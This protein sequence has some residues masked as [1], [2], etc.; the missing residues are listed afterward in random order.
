MLDLVYFT[1]FLLFL[2]SIVIL[3]CCY[4][5]FRSP[6]LFRLSSKDTYLSLVIFLSCS[7]SS[8]SKLF[9]AEFNLTL[10]LIWLLDL[11]ALRESSWFFVLSLGGWFGVLSKKYYCFKFHFYLFCYIDFRFAMFFCLFSGDVYAYIS[12][13]KYFFI[14]FNIFCFCNFFWTILWWT[15]WNICNLIS[16]FITNQITCCFWCWKGFFEVLLDASVTDYLASLRRRF[17][18]NIMLTFLLIPE[19]LPIFLSKDKIL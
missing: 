7:I 18:R 12:F 10:N 3:L 13:F 9:C 16:K 19:F 15:S 14:L 4:I 5:N 6:I 8:S 1:R 2:I 11:Q 17:W